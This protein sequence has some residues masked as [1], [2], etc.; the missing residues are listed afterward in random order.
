MFPAT[1]MSEK[2]ME[3]KT[4]VQKEII[5]YVSCVGYGK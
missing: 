1:V 2:E 4:I 3:K 5:K